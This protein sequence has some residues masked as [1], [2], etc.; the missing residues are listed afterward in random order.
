MKIE[1][2]LKDAEMI[3]EVPGQVMS[4]I[5]SEIDPETLEVIERLIN[6]GGLDKQAELQQDDKPGI[7]SRLLKGAIFGG[8]GAMPEDSPIRKPDSPWRYLAIPALAYGGF[9]LGHGLGRAFHKN[10]GSPA[11]YMKHP[12]IDDLL[13]RVNIPIPF[14]KYYASLSTP[15]ILGAGAG[16]LTAAGLLDYSNNH[17]EACMR[18]I[19]AGNVPAGLFEGGWDALKGMGKNFYQASKNYFS[20]KPSS[21]LSNFSKQIFE[22]VGSKGTFG[23]NNGIENLINTVKNNPYQAVGT[24]L[25]ITGLGHMGYKAFM[26][27]D[28]DRGFSK[29]IP[30]ITLTGLGLATGSLGPALHGYFKGVPSASTPAESA[31]EKR[32][33]EAAEKSKAYIDKKNATQAALE[34]AQREKMIAEHKKNF[35]KN[36]AER[37]ALGK[38]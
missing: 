15:G 24:G 28:D 7:T 1:A 26:D 8:A 34:K 22:G 9:H 35:A 36:R 19:A 14:S 21:T 27:K 17:K 25:G 29:Y 10:F 32:V 4:T 11:F 13:G 33:R 31:V 20:D 18:K 5:E 16:A 30:G 2:A 12:I 23:L 6:D 3:K 38:K 37:L